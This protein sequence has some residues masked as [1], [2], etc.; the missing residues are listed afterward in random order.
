MSSLA[1]APSRSSQNG[2]VTLIGLVWDAYRANPS[3]ETRNRLV[4]HYQPFLTE[5]VRRFGSR[6]PRAIDRGDLATAANVGLIAAI[7]GYD[8]SRGVPFETYCELRVRGALL[9]ELRS[10]DWLTRPMR[11]RLEQHKRIVAN[12]RAEQGREPRDDE[13]AAQMGMG[14]P[15]YEILFGAGLPGMPPRSSASGANDDGGQLDVVEDTRAASPDEALSREELLRLVAHRLTELEARI[16][17]LRYWENL[18]MRE[19]G[20]MLDLS[21]SRISKVHA[22]LLA[23]LQERLQNQ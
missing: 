2:A 22:R 9:D 5:L 13:I 15:D 4:E 18:P 11:A 6:L 21:E 19:I 16:V 20:E 23:R 14:L 7:S 8:P 3:D 12:L 10:E 1:T 17:Y